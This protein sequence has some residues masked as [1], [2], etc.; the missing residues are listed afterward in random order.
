MANSEGAA[1]STCGLTGRRSADELRIRGEY[2]CGCRP[3]VAPTRELFVHLAHE[4]L[5]SRVILG[6]AKGFAPRRYRWPTES[7]NSPRSSKLAGLVFFSA[8][9]VHASHLTSVRQTDRAT[10]KY[11]LWV[12]KKVRDFFLGGKCPPPTVDLKSPRW[13][14]YHHLISNH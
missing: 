2:K 8:E 3:L 11:Y 5:D 7:R 1:P 4:A 10:Y 9:G 12:Q 6:L 14:R 13:A